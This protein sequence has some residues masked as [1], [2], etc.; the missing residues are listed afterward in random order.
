MHKRLLSGI[1]LLTACSS[2]SGLLTSLEDITTEV[3]RQGLADV[4]QTRI[5]SIAGLL[6]PQ[7]PGELFRFKSHRSASTVIGLT[8]GPSYYTTA[9]IDV[10][11][12]PKAGEVPEP[13]IALRDAMLEVRQEGAKAIAKRLAL[14]NARQALAAPNVTDAERQ[15]VTAAEEKADAARATFDAALSKAMKLVKAGTL[16]MRWETESNTSG[17]LALGDILSVSGSGSKNTSGFAIL[18]GIRV[19]VLHVGRDIC[20]VVT[21]QTKQWHW[22]ET[23]FPWIYAP[24]MDEDVR[25]TSHLLQAKYVVWFQDVTLARRIAAHLKASSDQLGNIAK[26]LS[27]LDKIEI[28]LVLSSIQSLGNMGSMSGIKHDRSNNLTQAQKPPD[29]WQTVYYV[30]THLEDLRNL[31]K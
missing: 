28:D 30:D 4:N 5:L 14:A 17:N 7:Q 25:I 24:V 10:P 31:Y 16:V 19:S 22:F 12:P 1:L 29:G 26:T 11:D 23:S 9:T 15:A 20:E 2:T 18:H 3:D 8:D 13:L 21:N 27:D 6:A